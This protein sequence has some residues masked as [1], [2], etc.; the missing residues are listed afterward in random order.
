M[1]GA[2]QQWMMTSKGCLDQGRRQ[3]G[4]RCGGRP[5]SDRLRG[6]VGM[7]DFQTRPEEMGQ[8]RVQHKDHEV[9]LKRAERDVGRAVGH[10]RP[11]SVA[12]VGSVHWA[13]SAVGA[14]GG[15]LCRGN[16]EWV[17]RLSLQA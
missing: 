11:A 14:A 17:K 12:I 13:L 5:L 8:E 16:G 9:R 6:P 15:H 3:K 7:G 2:F 1:T 10:T 4:E